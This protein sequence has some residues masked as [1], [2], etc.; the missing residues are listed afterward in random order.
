MYQNPRRVGFE[1]SLMEVNMKSFPED[2]LW[3][4][5]CASYQCEGAWN[6]D[7]KGSNIWM[8]SHTMSAK[9]MW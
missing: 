3:G 9:D 8:I 1:Y 2:F 7:G 4:T 6:A 5:A